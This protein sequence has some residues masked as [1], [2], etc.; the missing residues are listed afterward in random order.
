MKVRILV[1][2]LS[3]GLLSLL[4]PASSQS[5]VSVG[6]GIRVGPPPA[7]VERMGPPPFA[8]AV[9]IHGYWLWNGPRARY[10]W[11]PGRWVAER[12]GFVWR[13]GRWAHS[14]RGWVWK[15]G[16]W[17][18]HE[19]RREIRHEHMDRERRQDGHRRGERG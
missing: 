5:Q 16:Y 14:G 10:T 9:W 15:E 4:T 18:R 7:R 6:I 13:D 11:Y 8:H 17:D 2:A 12:P 1:A 3:V 19:D